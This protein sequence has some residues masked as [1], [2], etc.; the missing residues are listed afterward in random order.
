MTLN[1]VSLCGN[2]A[3]PVPNYA[4][5]P[6]NSVIMEG[7]NELEAMCYH[8]LYGFMTCYGSLHRLQR[9]IKLGAC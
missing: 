2:L 1:W 7:C 9:L 6:K 3:P 8:A 4:P 5:V